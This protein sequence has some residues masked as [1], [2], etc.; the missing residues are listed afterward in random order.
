M[1]FRH[2]LCSLA[3]AEQRHFAR[4]AERPRIEQSP[5]SRALE[6]LEKELARCCLQAPR[7]TFEHEYPQRYPRIFQ[8]SM[9]NRNAQ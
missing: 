4:A 5:L 3:V 8:T 7:S 2:F 6:E 1:E 9:N